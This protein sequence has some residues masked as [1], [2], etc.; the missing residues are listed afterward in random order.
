MDGPNRVGR[1]ELI[2]CAFTNT[3]ANQTAYSPHV[4]PIRGQD[5]RLKL[6][7]STKTRLRNNVPQ[8]RNETKEK[9][10]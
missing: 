5:K 2:Q 3:T 4:K 8:H 7:S 1:E 10:P 9:T 6:A